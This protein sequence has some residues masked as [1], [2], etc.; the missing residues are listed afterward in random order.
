MR[1][2]ILMEMEILYDKM[3]NVNIE[4]EKENGNET[5]PFS[6]LL[7]CITNNISRDELFNMKD[8]ELL[9]IIQKKQLIEE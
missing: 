7:F 3:N 1:Q 8:I 6:K 4:F 2:E 5:M 9:K